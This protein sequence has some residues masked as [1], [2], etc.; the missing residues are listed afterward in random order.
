MVLFVTFFSFFVQNLVKVSYRFEEDG[1]WLIA[2]GS[3]QD[4]RGIDNSKGKGI[5]DVLSNEEFNQKQPG[6]RDWKW[7]P[8]K[9]M[10]IEDFNERKHTW[11]DLKRW[12]KKKQLTIRQIFDAFWL[13]KDI[14][15]VFPCDAVFPRRY[16]RC[17]RWYLN[18]DS[19]NREVYA[20]R[21]K[22]ISADVITWLFAPWQLTN[23]KLIF[24]SVDEKG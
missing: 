11:K 17:H 4:L 20:I 19:G 5:F 10:S 22:H 18:N 16:D 2:E 1:G 21:F 3:F 14:Y 23:L 8:S 12:K 15:G 24:Y 7:K 6:K 13:K 9:Q